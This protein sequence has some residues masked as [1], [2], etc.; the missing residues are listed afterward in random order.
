MQEAEAAAEHQKSVESDWRAIRDLQN[1]LNR[2]RNLLSATLRTTPEE[3]TTRSHAT[4]D[5]IRPQS[6]TTPAAS[7]GEQ[8]LELRNAGKPDCAASSWRR[9]AMSPVDAATEARDIMG[10]ALAS[11]SR[12]SPRCT[13]AAIRQ[14]LAR[15]VSRA[16]RA[17]GSGSDCEIV[18]HCASAE[19]LPGNRKGRRSISSPRAFGSDVRQS[20]PSPLTRSPPCSSAGNKQPRCH[21]SQAQLR[22]SRIR[23]N[24]RGHVP[25]RSSSAPLRSDR[26]RQHRMSAAIH[27][28][29]TPLGS[30]RGECAS[31]KHATCARAISS[32]AA[33]AVH[34]STSDIG[35]ETMQA[36]KPLA[37]SQHAPVDSDMLVRL[38][39]MAC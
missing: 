8:S 34:I 5:S 32:T 28:V 10:A 31:V 4:P 6:A 11:P 9:T 14:E 17:R 35:S 23:G 39:L 7:K 29:H 1:N 20:T 3:S 19:V 24:R 33:A 13:A 38:Q 25:V 18:T 15:M 21:V 12:K 30:S 16:E 26:S 22:I 36:R 2:T 27:T 37:C